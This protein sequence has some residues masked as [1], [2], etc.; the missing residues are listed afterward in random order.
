MMHKLE[1]GLIGIVMFCSSF[2]V[3][4]RHLYDDGNRYI[5]TCA[6][7]RTIASDG[8]PVDFETVATDAKNPYVV[9]GKICRSTRKVSSNSI[10]HPTCRAGRLEVDQNHGTN[11]DRCFVN[12]LRTINPTCPDN[13]KII[14]QVGLDVCEV[15]NYVYKQPGLI[16]P[17]KVVKYQYI[18]EDEPARR[19]LASDRTYEEEQ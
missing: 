1:L 17:M 4:A 19:G 16:R 3:Q 2:A 5:I 11:V 7:G 8:D 9:D 12:H 15:N 6:Q 10:V 18:Y 13:A 14:E